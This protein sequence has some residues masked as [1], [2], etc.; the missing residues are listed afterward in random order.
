MINHIFRHQRIYFGITIFTAIFGIVIT[1]V[2]AYRGARASEE[3]DLIARVQTIAFA[4]DAREL[5]FLSGSENDTSNPFYKSLKRRFVEINDANGDVRFI[6]LGGIREDGTIFF[7]LDS[8]PSGS[9]NSSPPGQEYTEASA[10][11]KE[12]FTLGISRFEGPLEDRWGNWVSAFA[13]IRHSGTGKIIAVLGMDISATEYYRRIFSTMAVPILFIL[14]FYA[15]VLIMFR[16]YIKREEMLSIKSGFVSIASHELRSPLTGLLWATQALLRSETIARY[17]EISS[18]IVL[19]ERSVTN[20]LAT[21]NGILDFSRLEHLGANGLLISSIDLSEIIDESINA[22]MLFAKEKGVYI[23]RED[24]LPKTIPTT[25]DR[26]GIKRAVNNVIANAVKYSSAPFTVTIAYR[27]SDNEHIISVSNN[28]NVISDEDRGKMF[29][30]FFRSDASR[31]VRVSRI[32]S[33]REGTGLG[34]YIAK[35][36]LEAHGG[37]IWYDSS[38]EKGTTFFISLPASGEIQ[39]S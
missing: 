5:S 28:G 36:I 17:P 16:E 23:A 4:F 19:M 14:L 1:G 34:L 30:K 8:E 6:Y 3:R 35:Q 25:G 15:I 29:S 31:A 24:A 2:A 9:L 33:G 39:K 27:L 32:P 26:E 20:M 21:V 12:V 18:T 13:P 37:R 22:L 7:Y 38:P 11:F 10:T